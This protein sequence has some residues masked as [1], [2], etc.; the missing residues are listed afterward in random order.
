MLF[1]FLG[2]YNFAKGGVIL[3][4]MKKGD[5]RNQSVRLMAAAAGIGAVAGLRSMTAPAVISLA[6]Q[7]NW[8]RVPRRLKFLKSQRTAA[9]LSALALGELVVDKLP[10]TPNRTEPVSLAARA[11]S[12]GLSAAVV[13]SS[14]PKLIVPGAASGA[15]AA[16]ASAFAGYTVRRQLDERLAVS[17]KVVAIAEDAVASGSGML[18]LRSA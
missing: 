14:K 9:V 10:G 18:L 11:V 17:D 4:R 5:G 7:R 15:L 6:A 2:E 8:I 13:C 16:I 1:G 3:D 12:G